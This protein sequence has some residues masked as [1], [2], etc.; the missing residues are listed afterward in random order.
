MPNLETTLKMRSRCSRH[1]R[2]SWT[3]YRWEWG[4]LGSVVFSPDVEHENTGDEQKR[5][6]KNRDG[7]AETKDHLVEEYQV[8]NRRSA[9]FW[10][11][12]HFDSR[13]VVS[14][15]PPHSSRTGSASTSCRSSCRCSCRR[16]SLSHRSATA[17][18]SRRPW[19]WRSASWTN[20]CSTRS[21][22]G[23]SM[24]WK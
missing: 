18:W 15:E 1:R 20:I 5:H 14:V 19:R 4:Y 3:L 16:L 23:L 17:S 10:L 21:W 9:Q 22:T 11:N 24:K 13:R 12:S 6:H 7:T 8:S 2:R